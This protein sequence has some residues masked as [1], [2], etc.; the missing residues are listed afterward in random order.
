MNNASH[1]PKDLYNSIRNQKKS[2]S[3]LPSY[4]KDITDFTQFET[5]I[6]SNLFFQLTNMAHRLNSQRKNPVL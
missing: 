3:Y 5:T 4:Y 6:I 2:D 1:T